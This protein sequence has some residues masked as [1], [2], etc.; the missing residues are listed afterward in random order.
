MPLQGEPHARTALPAIARWKIFD[1]LRRSL[2]PP[3]LLLLLTAGWLVLPG[4]P[5]LWT[6]LGFLVLFFPAYVQW[7]QTFTNRA[8]GVRLRDHLRI[9][10]DNLASSFHQ[11]LLHSAF[12]AHQSIV[13]LDAIGRT[14]ARLRSKKHLLEWQTAEDTA[15]RLKV[16]GP[17]VFQRMW[18]APVIAAVVG[19]AVLLLAPGSLFWAL[20]VVTLWAISPYL[21]YDTG[22]P[23]GDSRRDLAP[24]DRHEFRRT[25]RL[26][27]RFFEEV[28]VPADNWLVP[29]N[30]QENRPDP[31]AHRT[32]PTNIGLQMLAA[33]S[34]WDLGYLSTSECLVHLDRTFSTLE[35]LPRYRGHFFNWYDT[36]S[37]VPLAPLYVSTVDSG[38]LLGY[39]MTLSAT[40]PAMVDEQSARRRAFRRGHRRHARL[41]ERDSLARD[42]R[43][44]PRGRPRVPRRFSP[45]ARAARAAARRSRRRNA[46][47]QRI[48]R[49]TSRSLA[50]RLHDAQ[51]RLPAGDAKVRRPPGGSMRLPRWWPNGNAS[52]PHSRRHPTRPASRATKCTARILDRID[53]FVDGTEL[54]FLFDNERHLFAIGYNVTEGRR[55]STFYDALASEAR[56]ASFIAIAMRRVSQEHWFKLGR[57]MTP[58]GRHR[59]L[60]SWS[61]SMFEY[62]MPLLVMR[63]YPRTLLNETYEAVVS[64]HI[65]YAKA[66]GVPWGISESAYNVQDADAN[67]Q[68]RAFGVPGIGLEARA[69]RRSGHRTVRQPARRAH[70][71]EGGAGKSR[72]PRI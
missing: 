10:R 58:V 3:S 54:D 30:Y 12:L 48:S 62:L 35:K 25:A 67:Y 17:Q 49:L 5:S 55:D 71:A 44:G 60:V 61:A 8:R 50:A 2:L 13:M 33:V 19:L 37:L 15:A 31:I 65:E 21:A 29:D 39:L 72:A 64:R 53:Q 63:T 7:G 6:G 9:E 45:A 47:L 20:P 41:F 32:S 34:A 52:S 4:G 16:D 26:T 70:S 59:A 68:Y 42:D 51:E 28:V 23:R 57:L 11:V 24:R 43:P 22:L 18:A 66:L 27:W 40:L 1:N 38:N 69:G 56:L 14:L 36:Q 46:W